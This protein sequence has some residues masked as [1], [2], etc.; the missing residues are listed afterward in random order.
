MKLQ[1]EDD[2][3]DDLSSERLAKRQEQRCK[4][5]EDRLRRL[6]LRAAWALGGANA[7]QGSTKGVEERKRREQLGQAPAE[8]VAKSYLCLRFLGGRTCDQL[9]VASD[10]RS[11]IG[12]PPDWVKDREKPT[13]RTRKRSMQEL[14]KN[15]AVPIWCEHEE[16]FEWLF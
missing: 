14:D 15:F 11:G 16:P 1:D 13:R 5:G 6:N 7:S 3:A 10:A 12:V 4:T 9:V 8:P 2:C